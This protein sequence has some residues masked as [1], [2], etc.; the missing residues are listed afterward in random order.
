MDFGMAEYNTFFYFQ[1]LTIQYI[2]YKLQPGASVTIYWFHSWEK[3]FELNFQ[4]F[5][6]NGR[7]RRAKSPSQPVNLRSTQ[8]LMKPPYNHI[9]QYQHYFIIVW[10]KDY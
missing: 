6:L 1:L 4:N 10:Y 2:T 7:T 8:P 9:I 3:L 5:P